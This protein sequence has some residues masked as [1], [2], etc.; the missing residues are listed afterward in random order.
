MASFLSSSSS[1]SARSFVAA[2]ALAVAVGAPA[3]TARADD[4][5]VVTPKDGSEVAADQGVDDAVPPPEQDDALKDFVGTL[6]CSG[7]SAT[8]L[9]ADVPATFTL[10]VKKDLGARWL[11]ARSELVVKAKGARPVVAEEIWGWSRAKAGLVRAGATS[12]GSFV[13]STSTGWVGDRFAWSGEG[14]LRG[15]PAKEKLAFQ[16]TSPREWSVELSIGVD[17]LHVVFEGTCK[18]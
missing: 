3:G 17:E 14:A 16:R 6:R 18:R 7:T 15:R 2:A 1:S 8:E 10:S 13:Q 9:G 11:V 12:Q 5:L 4:G